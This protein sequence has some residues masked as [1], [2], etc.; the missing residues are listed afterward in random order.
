M[1]R[2]CE[3]PI[4]T[5]RVQRFDAITNFSM[6]L[7]PMKMIAAETQMALA[8]LLMLCAWPLFAHH[9]FSAEYNITQPM[10]LK[11]SISSIEWVNPHAY[12]TIAVADNDGASMEWRGEGGAL[13]FLKDSGWTPELLQQLVK[14][15][16]A[17]IVSG[18]RARALG[19]PGN[20]MWVKAIELPDGRRL[21][22]N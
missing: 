1:R 3:R 15:R 8:A 2:R 6:S 10:E 9:S 4:G 22:F 11:G 20:R 13:S 18:Y 5:D 14:S 19:T 12:V 21:V 17:V 16:G 7:K